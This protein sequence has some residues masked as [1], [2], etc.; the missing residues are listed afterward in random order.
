MEIFRYFGPALKPWTF[1]IMNGEQE[2]GIIT[3]K[4]SG[5]FKEAFSDADNFGIQFPPG[6]SVEQ[7]ALLLGSV[8]LIDFV[9]FENK[10]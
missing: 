7:K 1:K 3:K 4:W 5:L 2:V 6:L 9:H 8:F 10:N